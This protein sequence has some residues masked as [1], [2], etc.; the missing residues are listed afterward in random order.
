MKLDEFSSIFGEEYALKKRYLSRVKQYGW[1]VLLCALLSTIIGYGVI[2]IQK[3]VYQ[4]TAT[5]YVVADSPG[6]SFQT[7][8]SANDSVALATNYASQILSSS[9]M[10]YVYQSDPHLKARGYGPGDLLVDVTANPSATSSTFQVIASA[11]N[12]NDAAM[13]ANDVANGFQAYIQAQTQ[14]QLNSVRTSLQNQMAAAEK[15]K[16][17]LEASLLTV[18]SNTDP[19]YTVYNSELNDVYHTI[20]TLQQQLI[21]LPANATSNVAVIQ[22]ATPAS[23]VPA[24]KPNLLVAITAAIGLLL[25]I[26]IML[27][28]I[29]LDNR[30][31]GEDQIRERLQMAYLGAVAQQRALK[32]NPAR[33]DDS[34]AQEVGD[35]GANLRLLGLLPGRKEASQAPVLLVTSAQVSEG[36]TTLA[37]ALASAIASS[38][39]TVLLIDANLHYPAAHLSYGLNNSKIG[40]SG[41]LRAQVK[42]DD[43]VQRTSI[44][45]IW[46]MTGGEPMKAHGLLFEQRLPALLSHLR[47]K[48]D[49]VIIDGPAVLS[50][51][52]AGIL[53]SMADGVVL[54]VDAR[55]DR[56]P[57]LL[58]VKEILNAST[59]APVGIVMNRLRQRGHNSYYVASLP[60]ASKNKEVVAVPVAVSLPTPPA[61][62]PN[63]VRETGPEPSLMWNMPVQQSMPSLLHPL[64]RSKEEMLPPTGLLRKRE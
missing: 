34:T 39:S 21:G 37:T 59:G 42:V 33:L 24:V 17:A 22:L 13:I 23:A 11:S 44:P 49:V 41:V 4:A 63:L 38:G 9:V 35:I 6:N 57:M 54:V 60:A 15:Q 52:E 16:A 19:H 26:L 10:D 48:A 18:A 56:L 7:S 31:Q 28:V 50:G 43:A 45:G 36:K 51:S 47:S 25:G 58:R 20:D 55:H 2:K 14:Q 64:G 12:Q 8:L 40:L 62:N 3:P 29:Y 27:L 1:I 46:L 32:D 53:A 61:S 5:M 30:L